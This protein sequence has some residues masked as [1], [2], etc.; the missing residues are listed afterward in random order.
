MKRK[1]IYGTFLCLTPFAASFLQS[2]VFLGV[3]SDGGFF[4]GGGCLSHFKLK[5]LLK[6]SNW[7]RFKNELSFSLKPK[8]KQGA[9]LFKTESHTTHCY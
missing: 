4:P 6:A 8:N 2:E 9:G 7:T 1:R 5:K 3:K